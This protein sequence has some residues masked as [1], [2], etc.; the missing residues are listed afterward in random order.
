MAI[1]A[2]LYRVAGLGNSVLK[3]RRK[4][5]GVELNLACGHKEFDVAERL[6]VAEVAG[7]DVHSR[8]ALGSASTLFPME[9]CSQ[10]KGN[11]GIESVID[12]IKNWRTRAHLVSSDELLMNLDKTRWLSPLYAARNFI[13]KINDDGGILRRMVD[14]L[15]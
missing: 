5:D 11:N 15:L 3:I 6:R 7:S 9:Y 1:A 8:I 2:H 10:I 14:L 13:E 4:I 12:C